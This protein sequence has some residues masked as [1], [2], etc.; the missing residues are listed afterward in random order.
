ML[1]RFVAL[2]NAS[3]LEF[4]HWRTT[5]SIVR[6]SGVFA[7]LDDVTL[8]RVEALTKELILATDITRQAEFL[9]RLKVG[10]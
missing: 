7:H 1:K 2:Q 5:L 4:H 3:V 8:T 10:R 9:A 6:E